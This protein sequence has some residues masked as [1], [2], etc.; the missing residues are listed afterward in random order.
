MNFYKYFN[1][2]ISTFRTFVQNFANISTYIVHILM[3]AYYVFK[4]ILYY[5]LCFTLF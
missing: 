3:F 1:F 2:C 4:D 5:T